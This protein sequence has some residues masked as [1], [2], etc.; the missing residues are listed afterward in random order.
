MTAISGRVDLLS[1]RLHDQAALPHLKAAQDAITEA[2][3]MIRHLHNFAAG[4]PEPGAVLVDLNQLVADSV[5]MA[6]SMWFQRFRQSRVAVDIE[7]DLHPLPAFLGRAPDL[8]LALLC[9]LRHAMDTFRLE[10][11]L[12]VCTSTVAGGEGQTVAVSFSADGEPP[13]T[14]ESAH[15]GEALV[16]QAY[17]PDGNELL[18]FVEVLLR[19]LDARVTVRG[20]GDGRTT[21]TVLLLSAN[22]GAAAAPRR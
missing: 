19:P 21:T 16:K 22:R 13:C 10:R 5:Q 3:Q 11:P 9:L 4:S 15:G 8:R 18:A 20:S 12:F 6:R 1:H 2:S 17:T 14:S 7:T